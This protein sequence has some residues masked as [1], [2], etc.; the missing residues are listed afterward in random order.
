MEKKMTYVEA[1]DKALAVVDDAIV[2]ERLTALKASLEKRHAKKAEGPSKV[3]VANAAISAKLAEV[4]TEGA[5]YGTA[6]LVGIIPEVEKASPSKIA[7]LMRPLVESGKVILGKS[8][9]KVT[10]TVA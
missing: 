7:V 2:A 4:L 9:G 6:D 10:Y 5:V 3:A 8:K 1:L